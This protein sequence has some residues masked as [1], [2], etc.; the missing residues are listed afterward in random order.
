M[1]SYD[2]IEHEKFF[3]PGKFAVL[4]QTKLQRA[5]FSLRVSLFVLGRLWNRGKNKIENVDYLWQACFEPQIRNVFKSKVHDICIVEYVHF[6]KIFEFVPN[7]TFKVLDTHDSFANEFSFA[8]E[9]KGFLRADKVV[10]IQDEEADSFKMQLG[11]KAGK[12]RVISHFV[13][14]TECIDLSS[15]RGATFLGS[16]F[17]AN[18]ISV[19]YFIEEVLPKVRRIVPDFKLYIAGDVGLEIEGQASVVKL[20]R[21]PRL[22]DA[23]LQA[24]I[25]VN[26]TRAGTGAKIKLLEAIGLGIPCVST[27]SGVRGIGADFLKGCRIVADDDTEAFAQEVAQLV[28]N[29]AVR[30]ALGTQARQAAVRWNDMQREQ[31]HVLLAEA[32]RWCLSNTRNE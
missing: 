21:V 26:P 18:L 8:A 27:R 24:P 7:S 19:R 15:T 13:N 4:R 30:I 16:R 23:F 31:L 3:G 22:A 25:L 28:S 10:A 1:K 29:Q 14:I 20:G 12:V 5:L 17:E 6:S 2:Q 11:S 9:T 32:N